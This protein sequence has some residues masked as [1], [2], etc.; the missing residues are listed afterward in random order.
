MVITVYIRHARSGESTGRVIEQ[1]A[2]AA[3]T[4]A[5]AKAASAGPRACS[6]V[7]V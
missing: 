3:D 2:S 5:K 7:Q 6:A 4:S 1:L